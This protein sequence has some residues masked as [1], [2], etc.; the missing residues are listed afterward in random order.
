MESLFSDTPD[1][2]RN[3]GEIRNCEETFRDM[4]SSDH[5]KSLLKERTR[6]LMEFTGQS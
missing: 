6:R 4:P 1:S 5:T 2:F 3:A